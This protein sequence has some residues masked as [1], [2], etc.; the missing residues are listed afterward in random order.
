MVKTCRQYYP[1][2]AAKPNALTWS[3]DIMKKR[4]YNNG[5]GEFVLEPLSDSLV[6][7]IHRDQ[8]GY[9]GIVKDWDASAPFASTTSTFQVKDEEIDTYFGHSTPEGALNW[10][11]RSMLS[12]Q[13]KV[14]SKR[15]NPEERKKAARQVLREFLEELPD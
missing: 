8:T 3:R 10:L 15:I 9:L 12:D 5:N 14:D 4:H 13:R 11:C 6:K 1:A 7:V 2:N